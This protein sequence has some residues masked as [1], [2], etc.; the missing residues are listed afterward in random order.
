MSPPEARASRRTPATEITLKGGGGEKKSREFAD[1]H[2][3]TKV[4]LWGEERER[5]DTFC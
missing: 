3:T 2:E 5:E 1:F 4:P